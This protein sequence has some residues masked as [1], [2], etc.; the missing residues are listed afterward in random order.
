VKARTG[1][2]RRRRER[3]ACGQAESF[4]LASQAGS[5]D[6]SGAPAG[7]SAHTSDARSPDRGAVVEP[8]GGTGGTTSHPPETTAAA[9][10][11]ARVALADYALEFVKSIDEE[12]QLKAVFVGLLGDPDG[13]IR[14][15]AAELLVELAYG[16]YAR[17]GEEE[18]EG[19]HRISWDVPRP[20]RD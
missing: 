20:E 11:G 18:E 9:K 7:G 13:R 3:E 6:S 16:K 19:P 4:S 17:R 1:S 8:G 15:R 10:T 14:L 5:S 12:K 2:S